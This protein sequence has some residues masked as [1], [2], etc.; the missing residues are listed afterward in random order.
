MQAA[1]AL[2]IAVWRVCCYRIFAYHADGVRE[3]KG[4]RRRV[5]L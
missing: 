5:K 3:G 1:V 4:H 2:I